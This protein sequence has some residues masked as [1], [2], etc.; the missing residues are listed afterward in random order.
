MKV[1][2]KRISTRARCP[3]KSAVGSA[4]YDLFGARNIVL[5][6]GSTRSVEIEIDFF[7]SNKYVSNIHPRSRVSLR[8]ILVG[9]GII[10]SDFRGNVRVILHNFSTNRLEFST[11]DRIAQVL[12]QNKESSRLIEVEIFDNFVTDRNTKGFGST[13]IW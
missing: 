12:L 11:G 6:P 9:G 2:F 13:G 10:D 4:Y 1:R 5:E 3:Q 8:S 7:F